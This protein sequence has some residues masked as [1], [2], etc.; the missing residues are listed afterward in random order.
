MISTKFKHAGL[1]VILW[2][3]VTFFPSSLGSGGIVAAQVVVTGGATTVAPSTGTAESLNVPAGTAPTSPVSGAMFFDGKELYFNDGVASQP[4]PRIVRLAADSSASTSTTM[5]N[6][7]GMSFSLAVHT[8]YTVSCDVFYQVSATTGGVTL[9]F[10]GPASPTNVIFGGYEA[11]G[12]N[13]ATYNSVASSFG[14]SL[15]N[16]AANIATTNLSVHISGT[17][18]VGSSSGTLQLQYANVAAGVGSVTIKRGSWC[19]V[20]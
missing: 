17:I 20:Q 19:T 9:T 18:E 16:K 2:T 4:L 1:L 10:T 8:I 6:L 15:Y 3:V 13:N 14:T 11:Y 5:S 7:T 12:S